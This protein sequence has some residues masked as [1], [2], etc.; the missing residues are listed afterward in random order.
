[1]DVVIHFVYY[2]NPL[3]PADWIAHLNY[4]YG[5]VAEIKAIGTDL[6]TTYRG[7]VYML[8]TDDFVTQDEF[9]RRERHSE[10]RLKV[11]TGS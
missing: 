9:D 10:I 6:S 5:I 2:V 3:V 11:R 1:M 8:A 4:F 7:E